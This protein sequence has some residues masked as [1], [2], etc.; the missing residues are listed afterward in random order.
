MQFAGEL[1]ALATAVCWASGSMFFAAAGRR[2]GS[3]VLNRLRITVACVFLGAALLATRGSPWPYW[4]TPL[5][6][7]LLAL[8]GLIG[9]VFGDRYY[10]KSL[11]ILGPSRATLVY[12]T[13]PLFTVVIAWPLLHEF[14]GTLVFLGMTLTLGGIFLVL[15]GR[16][17]HQAVHPEGSV[18][19]GV[20]AGLLGALGQAGGYVIS[21]IALRE[22]LDPLSATVIRIV[23]AMIGVWFL[24]SL[25]KGT[26]ARSFAALRDR[27]AAALMVG[28]AF[29]GPFLGVTLSLAALKFIQAGVAA[30]IIA[31]YPILTL[32]LSTLFHGEKITL[33]TLFGTVVAVAGVVVLFVR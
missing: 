20:I 25:K 9:F 7:G 24:A 1:S 29:L 19:V 12:S 11:V 33:R 17:D 26:A 32:F 31:I 10:F 13:A 21:K 5:Q 16:M 4:A 2:M 3:G 6:V 14:P 30:S 23:A 18:S 8:S 27:P 28:G 15:K 22:G